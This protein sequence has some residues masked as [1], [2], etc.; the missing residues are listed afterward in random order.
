MTKLSTFADNKAHGR[1]AP[2][3]NLLS[4]SAG[5]VA[6]GAVDISVVAVALDLGSVGVE[7]SEAVTTSGEDLIIGS[8][9]L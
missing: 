2:G 5:V 4:V 8:V 3:R 6:R 9:L 1:A 7:E